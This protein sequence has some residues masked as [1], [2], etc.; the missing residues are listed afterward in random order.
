MIAAMGIRSYPEIVIHFLLLS[1]AVNSLWLQVILQGSALYLSKLL[2][3]AIP[4]ISIYMIHAQ[5]PGARHIMSGMAAVAL[6]PLFIM[7][8]ILNNDHPTERAGEAIDRFQLRL[9]SLCS[10]AALL[11]TVV[12]LAEL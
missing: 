7:P 6:I 5:L 11:A 3:V 4:S 1:A 12:N 2:T 9:G 10:T 8:V